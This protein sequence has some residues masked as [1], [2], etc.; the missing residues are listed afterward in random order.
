MEQEQIFESLGG[1]TAEGLPYIP[2]DVYQTDTGTRYLRHPG[3]VMIA[4]PEVKLDGMRSFLEGF[5]DDL[6]FPGYLE[7]PTPL[8]SGTQLLKT[9][10]QTCYSSFGPKRTTNEN[11]G[12]YFGNTISSGHGSILEHASYSFF[13]YGISRSNTHEVVRHRA[14][15]AFSQL[16]QR[17]VSGSVLRFVERL[18]YQD[19][20]QLHK[21]FEERIDQ[22]AKEYSD[23]TDELLALQTEGHPSLTAEARTDMRKRVQQVARSVLP[24]ET[25]TTMVLTANVRAWRHMVEMRTEQHAESEIRDLFFRV[26]L[27]L[28]KVEPILFGDYEIESYGDGTYGARTD[29]RKA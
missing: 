11:A 26:F 12:R 16:S 22:L 18:E 7:D 6:Q 8:P 9:A 21:R 4:R 14:G 15:T 29:W 13:L 28:A 17:F 1:K 19:V 24:N 2:S 3:V 20:P 27:C 23:V 5:E 25:E 10:G